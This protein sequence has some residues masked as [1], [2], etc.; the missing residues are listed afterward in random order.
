MVN[1]LCK[2]EEIDIHK[3]VMEMNMKVNLSDIYFMESG[4]IAEDL[5]DSIKNTITK[6]FDK[7]RKVINSI[8]KKMTVSANTNYL[9]KLKMIT[10][11]SN[12]PVIVSFDI[13]KI[14]N[15]E[16]DTISK[17]IGLIG[18]MRTLGAKPLSLETF[19]KEYKSI[20][21]DMS[22]MVD[23]VI[24]TEISIPA[25]RI[26]NSLKNVTNRI[27]TLSSH[28]DKV[29]KTVLDIDKIYK[30]NIITEK[31]ANETKKLHIDIVNEI[32]TIYITMSR[33]VYVIYNDIKNHFKID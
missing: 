25:Q 1:I 9:N 5:I 13:D 31:Y 18:K 22:R 15:I 33:Q 30:S 10:N 7:I 27:D 24:H 23:N 6:I 4:N 19:K 8:K 32:S 29:E 3:L 17:L 11:N 14:F 21:D 28:V 16:Y 2:R 26:V 12:E 20:K